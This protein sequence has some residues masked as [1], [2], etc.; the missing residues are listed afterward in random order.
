MQDLYD[1]MDKEHVQKRSDKTDSGKT[2]T[3]EQ[4]G[5]PPASGAQSACY[6]AGT[7]PCTGQLVW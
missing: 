6:S 1:V 7:E 4:A 2:T 5:L 3:G